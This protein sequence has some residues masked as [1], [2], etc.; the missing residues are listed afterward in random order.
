[1]EEGTKVCINHDQDGRHA[2]LWLKPYK[3]FSRIR[4]PMI[5]KLDMRYQGL[6]LY[7]IYL[8][9]YPGLTLR[10]LLK[11]RPPWGETS[12]RG[13]LLEKTSLGRYL[14]GKRPPLEETSLGRDLL[15]K[16]PPKEE[17]SLGRNLLKKRPP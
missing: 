7:K 14:I 5:L 6:E 17:T 3:I 12:L 2:L 16:R 8:N 10:D 1:M 15:K 9:G 13:D 4:S 11:K